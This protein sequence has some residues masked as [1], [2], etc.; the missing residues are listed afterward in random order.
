MFKY[1]FLLCL[2]FQVYA[3]EP[4]RDLNLL[5][6]KLVKLSDE[7]SAK[8]ERNYSLPEGEK[9]I[10]A[11]LKKFEK[12]EIINHN[13]FHSDLK[14]KFKTFENPKNL[15]KPTDERFYPIF[16]EYDLLR[17]LAAGIKDQS[18]SKEIRGKIYQDILTYLK[19][20]ILTE[21]QTLVEL[22]VYF[23]ILKTLTEIPELHSHAE[24]ISNS[25]KEIEFFIQNQKNMMK[26]DNPI[27]WATELKNTYYGKSKLI[28]A[29]FM[30]A[31]NI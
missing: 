30:L 14:S 16:K 1:L 10:L 19:Q 8:L 26:D 20:Q 12:L 24:K 15:A 11:I 9:N 4:H 3:L 31:N 29:L 22:A 6:S 25:A 27:I 5:I 21:D 28:E 13:S 23:E 2:S 18:N 7:A 17:A